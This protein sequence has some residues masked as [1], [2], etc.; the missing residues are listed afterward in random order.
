[1]GIYIYIYIC[2]ERERERESFLFFWME[3]SH[4]E[5]ANQRMGKKNMFELE[6]LEGWKI[7]LS[8]SPHPEFLNLG[9]TNMW[10]GNSLLWE[11]LLCIL[12]WLAASLAYT[13]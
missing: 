1:M 10:A 3:S 12:T 7:K 9:M 8:N 5:R 2:R 13:Y 11:A 6:T 4:N